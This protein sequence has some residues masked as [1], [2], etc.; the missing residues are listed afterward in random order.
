MLGVI[1]IYSVKAKT[2]ATPLVRRKTLHIVEGIKMNETET[3]ILMGFK[4]SIHA[5]VLFF[6]RYKNA[7]LSITR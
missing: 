1:V 4:E 5:E 6:D 7:N 3:Q 2:Q